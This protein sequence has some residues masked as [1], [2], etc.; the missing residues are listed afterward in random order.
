M[1]GKFGTESASQASGSSDPNRTH[2]SSSPSIIEG[3]CRKNETFKHAG[4]AER[5]GISWR[6]WASYRKDL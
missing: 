1:A 5:A 6:R 2:K 3:G 4:A